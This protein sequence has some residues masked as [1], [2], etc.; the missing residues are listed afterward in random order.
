MTALATPS[1]AY[2]STRGGCPPVGFTEA[3]LSGLAP[4]GGLYVPERVPRLSPAVLAHAATAPYHQTAA[5][6]LQ[7]FAGPEVLSPAEAE[8]ITARAYARQWASPAIAPLVQTGPGAWLMELFHGPSLAFKDVAMQLIAGLYDVL[9]ARADRRL[10]VICATSGDTGGA[11]VEAFAT[12]A[13]VQMFVLL[14]EGRVSD[15]QRRFMTASGAQ[16]VHPLVL[17]GDF[18][19]AQAIVK[20]LLADADFTA[21]V[22]LSPVNS[23][24]WARILAQ[25]V[26]YITAAAALG[27]V[28]TPVHFTVP[29]GNLGDAYAGHLA[30]EMGANIGRIRIVTNANAALPQTFATGRFIRPAT[31]HATLSPAMDIALASN[32]ERLVHDALGRE[33][34]LTA[35][36]YADLAAH[37]QFNLPQPARDWLTAR[38]D[39]VSVDDPTTEAALR[40]AD[41]TAHQT[42]CPHAAVGWAARL[43]PAQTGGPCVLLATAHPAK[44]PETVS[45]VLGRAPALPAHC[46]DLYDRPEVFAR[47]PASAD[48]VRAV[49]RATLAPHRREA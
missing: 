45:A 26:Y 19:A 44:F 15:V 9:L 18:D 41:A 14:P 13:R 6:V 31:S 33:P 5:A 3:V 46:A 8:A 35:R 21:D 49:I 28:G 34:A 11:A 48:A 2:V 16:N 22:G 24:N 27:R 17:D 32:F 38:F 30:R 47:L 1:P 12:S 25:S 29:S 7:A 43:T 39:A 36:A 20:A 10:S 42:L 40:D 37:G 23:I 4:D